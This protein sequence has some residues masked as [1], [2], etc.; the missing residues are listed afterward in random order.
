ME[1]NRRL[2]VDLQLRDA[3]IAWR[4]YYYT[5]TMEDV[6]DIEDVKQH[7]EQARSSETDDELVDSVCD[8]ILDSFGS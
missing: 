8:R 1:T 2:T 6:H 3:V 5:Q 7:L 4:D